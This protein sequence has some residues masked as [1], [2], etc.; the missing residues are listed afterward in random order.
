MDAYI[1]R[2]WGKHQEVSEVIFKLN[3]Q[4]IDDERDEISR[5]SLD[6]TSNPKYGVLYRLKGYF[7]ALLRVADGRTRRHFL[8]FKIWTT[9]LQIAHLSARMTTKRNV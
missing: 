2:E 6:N 5:C 4:K 1:N 9:N 7:L 3:Q 8:I